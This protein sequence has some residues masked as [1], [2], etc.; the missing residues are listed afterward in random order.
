LAVIA[1]ENSFQETK[2]PV[3]IIIK[4]LLKGS[5]AGFYEKMKKRSGLFSKRLN[6]LM[7]KS[8]PWLSRL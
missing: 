5:I 7:N 8:K 4:N 1:D 6:L 3:E 2:F